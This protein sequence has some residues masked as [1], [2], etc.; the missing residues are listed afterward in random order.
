MDSD[1]KTHG[2]APEADDTRAKNR[3]RFAP[4]YDLPAFGTGRVP[5]DAAEDARDL[6]QRRGRGSHG[7]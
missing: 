2:V 1:Q 7:V 3:L 4:R 5:F 6:G